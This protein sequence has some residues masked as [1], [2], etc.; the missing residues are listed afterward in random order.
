MKRDRRICGIP[1]PSV[2]PLEWRI[3]EEGKRRMLD[4]SDLAGRMGRAFGQRVD[5]GEVE[6]ALR[7]LADLGMIR[8]V[9]P[10]TYE[11]SVYGEKQLFPDIT[12]RRGEGQP[13]GRMSRTSWIPSRGRATSPTRTGASGRPCPT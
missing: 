13:T 11:I 9:G 5:V 7:H 1:I 2:T 10:Q 3:L 4:A 6:R 12:G 8:R